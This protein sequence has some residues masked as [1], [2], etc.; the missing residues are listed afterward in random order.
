M[1]GK[2]ETPSRQRQKEKT[3]QGG[4]RPSGMP[5][6]ARSWQRPGRSSLQLEG[7]RFIVSV[8]L[9]QPFTLTSS[10]VCCCY[11]RVG[12]TTIVHGP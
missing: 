9:T 10:L 8:S 1:W 7:K 11:P 3:H 12:E 6:M 5:K 4:R 2:T